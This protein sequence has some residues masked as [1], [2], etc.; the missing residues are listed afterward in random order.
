MLVR[1]EG[2]PLAIDH[3]DVLDR[4]RGPIHQLAPRDSGVVP[5]LGA[6]LG[7]APVDHLVGREGRIERHVEQPA[8]ADAMNRRHALLDGSRHLARRIGDAELASEPLGDQEPAARQELHRPW[9]GQ[10]RSNH[11]LHLIPGVGR[12]CR[13]ARLPGKGRGVRALVRIARFSRRLGDGDKARPDRKRRTRN[14]GHD[15]N[16]HHQSP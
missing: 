10:T 9:R 8:L 14:R 1:R 11:F 7:I 5:P 12:Q 15:P 4:R 13:R 2:R 6:G 16:A 3:R